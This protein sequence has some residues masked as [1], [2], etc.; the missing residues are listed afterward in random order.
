MDEYR[1]ESGRKSQNG[2]EK[3]DIT[4]LLQDFYHGI[5]KLWWLV[6]VLTAFFAIKNYFSVT[7]SYVSQYV[8]SATVSVTSATGS[9][10]QDMA[11]VFPYIMTSGVLAE[12]V[13]EDL[14][15]ESLPGTINAEA[16]EGTN[17]LTISVTA[18][19]PQVAY[20][21]LVSVLEN[22]PE[23]AEF[24]VGETKLTILDETGIPSDTM[25]AEVIRGSYKRGAL[26]G[27]VIGMLIIVCY[28]LTRRTVK[29]KKTLKN[30]LNLKECGTIPY[31]REKKRKKETFHNSLSL[32]NDRLSLGYMEALRKIRIKVMTEME[33]N[34]Y[35]TLMVTSSVPGEGKTTLAANLAISIAKQGK[36]VMLLDCDLRNPSIAGVMN[37]KEKHPGIGSVLKKEVML[38]DAIVDIPLSSG[39]LKV[40]YGSEDDEKNTKLLGTRTMQSLIHAL[41]VQFD[42]VI[43]DTAPSGILADAPVLARYVDSALYVIRYDYVKM[44]HIL[45]G[46]QSLAMSGIHIL[47]YV[48]NG[49]N[50]KSGSYGYG[51]GRYGS[52]GKYGRYGSYGRYG[53]YGTYG[54]NGERGSVDKDGRVI[55]E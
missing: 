29:S 53:H 27:A 47:G 26:K 34:G 51:Y 42:F 13:S 14:G 2:P 33:E 3:I 10:A 39:S 19:D 45:D 9:S 37:E 6:I 5:R 21:T 12:V 20:N 40:L 50:S 7:T 28:V 46:V 25:R 52:Y 1:E 36:N 44:R 38:K 22:Y 4:G 55:K 17:L 11:Q 8:A 24:V 41:E 16:D 35:K 32:L 43:L 23:V 49:D 54:N 48:F 18:G 30:H 31:I 15:V